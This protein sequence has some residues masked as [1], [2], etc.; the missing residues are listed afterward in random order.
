MLGLYLAVT[1]ALV[2][3]NDQHDGA[4][5]DLHPVVR[6]SVPAV[7]AF[8]VARLVYTT[9]DPLFTAFVHFLLAMVGLLV[10]AW[11]A[12]YA[13]RRLLGSTAGERPADAG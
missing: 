2:K 5:A 1:V 11:P 13:G 6:F 12:M 8:G 3:T 4:V 9:P 7:L 10:A